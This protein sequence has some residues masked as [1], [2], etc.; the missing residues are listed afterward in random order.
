MTDDHAP[1]KSPEKSIAEML[2][3]AE[4][5]ALSGKT[6]EAAALH[7][8]ILARDPK[9][10]PSLSFL[11]QE[12]VTQGRYDEAIALVERFIAE[13]PDEALHR[14][15][16]GLCHAAKRDFASAARAFREAID[17]DQRNPL[18]YLLYG[19]AL[20]QMGEGMRAAAAASA[21]FQLD[22]G[23]AVVK[24]MSDVAPVIASSIQLGRDLLKAAMQSLHQAAINDTAKRFP[25]EKLERVAGA[26][27]PTS[28][29][30]PKFKDPLQRP[31]VFYMPDLKPRAVYERGSFRWITDLEAASD[32]II[33]EYDANAAKATSVFAL[34]PHLGVKLEVG[35]QEAW[36]AVYLYRNTQAVTENLALFPKTAAILKSLPLA[37]LGG[38]PV[39]AYFSI[40][41][42]GARIPAHCGQVNSHVTVHLPLHVTDEASLKIGGKTHHHRPGKAFVFDDSFEHSAAN[43]GSK[44]RVVLIFEV[45]NPQL[46]LA[47]RAAVEA[48]FARRKAWY[49][50]RAI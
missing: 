35:G 34:E 42:P 21:A 22:P 44:P 37:Q 38:Q 4:V 2:E 14:H 24:D 46:S 48:S 25:G 18:S 26:L 27:W 29:D 1:E 49:E 6:V 45:W 3:D 5:K 31:S 30:S 41:A 7:E 43:D 12:A 9:S 15:S 50:N 10:K 16:L 40:L 36:Q 11:A 19:T 20:A 33:A 8:A 39:N 28:Q 17:I 13:E 47:E 32:D 23:L